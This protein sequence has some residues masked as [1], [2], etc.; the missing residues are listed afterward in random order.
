MSSGWE[1][2][3][4]CRAPRQGFDYGP[5]ISPSSDRCIST[6]VEERQTGSAGRL[7]CTVHAPT[8]SIRAAN[9]SR[10]RG[11]VR[12][13]V[14]LVVQLLS[15]QIRPGRSAHC[16]RKLATTRLCA[17]RVG[18]GR[19]NSRWLLQRFHDWC[20]ARLTNPARARGTR[21]ENW[22]PLGV[23]RLMRSEPRRLSIA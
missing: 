19:D 9:R 8:G 2:W 12:V 11:R 23:S 13:R 1:I 10:C 18:H 4:A 16:G 7:G 15:H 5:V 21:R 20:N 14:F 3:P 17:S 22:N 6:G